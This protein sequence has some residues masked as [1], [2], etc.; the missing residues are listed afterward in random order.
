MLAARELARQAEL[1]RSIDDDDQVEVA[2]QRRPR[3]VD[4]LDH[5]D[6]GRGDLRELLAEPPGAPVVAAV[7][8]LV[9]AQERRQHLVAQPL[10]VEREV[11][12]LERR[13]RLARALGQGT[14]EVVARDHRDVV[15]QQRELARERALARAARAVD[16]D[17]DRR[18][19]ALGRVDR[20]RDELGRCEVAG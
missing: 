4:A 11:D 7:A 2:A 5:D 15:A 9:A 16:A 14:V 10:P 19:L 13:Q 1:A 18:P 8:R 17:D 3:D 12:R 6:A 20:V